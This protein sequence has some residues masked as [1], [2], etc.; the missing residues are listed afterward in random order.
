M[1]LR[2]DPT[3]DW[4]MVDFSLSESPGVYCIYDP[5]S[6]RP[7][8]GSSKN[9]KSRIQNHLNGIGKGKSHNSALNE[10]FKSGVYS[11]RFF[12]ISYTETHEGAKFMEAHW[13]SLFFSTGLLNEQ[14]IW[15]SAKYDNDTLESVRLAKAIGYRPSP[16]NKE[17]D[18]LIYV[19]NG[20]WQNTSNRTSKIH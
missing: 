14:G 12:A 1:L 17:G 8:I 6:L 7:Y 13:A 2:Q 10:V 4:S 19:G 16:L 9:V 5:N 11:L 18:L 20:K 3:F 15:Y